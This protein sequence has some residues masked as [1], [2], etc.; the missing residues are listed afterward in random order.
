MM[1]VVDPLSSD[2]GGNMCAGGGM[3]RTCLDA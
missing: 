1:R 3:M 2:A